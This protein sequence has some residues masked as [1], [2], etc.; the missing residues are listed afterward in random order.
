[1]GLYVID[2]EL[3]HTQISLGLLVCFFHYL[4]FLEVCSW[5]LRL[6]VTC[7]VPDFHR[8][9]IQNRHRDLLQSGSFFQCPVSH[10]LICCCQSHLL[11]HLRVL[12]HQVLLY[13]QFS[14]IYLHVF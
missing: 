6:G 10:P 13:R 4:V 2:L 3:F 1:M 5:A 14:L 11:H 12:V 9:Q 7:L 8:E